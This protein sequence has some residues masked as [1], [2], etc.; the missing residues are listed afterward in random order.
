MLVSFLFHAVEEGCQGNISLLVQDAVK[1]A[2]REGNHYRC[3]FKLSHTQ[4]TYTLLQAED[5]SREIARD[6]AAVSFS[7]KDSDQIVSVYVHMCVFV[8]MCMCVVFMYMC[9]LVYVCICP[10]LL[11]LHCV[12]KGAWEKNRKSAENC[13]VRFLN[14]WRKVHRQEHEGQEPA[15]APHVAKVTNVVCDCVKV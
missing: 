5:V 8:Y 10:L 1:A 14:T 11:H 3:H 15:V 6:R 9:V 13:L 7:P 2:D 4:H 12:R